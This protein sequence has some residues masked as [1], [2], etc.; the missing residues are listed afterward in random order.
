MDINSKLKQLNRSLHYILLVTVV[1]CGVI[2]RTAS[3][4]NG[5]VP[6]DLQVKLI[7]TALTY[8]K[9]LETRANGQLNIGI[10]YFPESSQ[11]EKEANQFVKTLDGFKDKKI[12]GRSFNGTLLSYADN[13]GLRKK[14]IDKNIDVLYIVHGKKELID[15]VL[16][17]TRSEKILSCTCKAELVTSCGVTMAVGLKDNKPK[18]YLNLSS[19]KSEGADFSA[20]FLRVAEIVGKKESEDRSQK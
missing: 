19:A 20:K 8:D 5:N 9:S 14:I 18:I 3:A 16:K 10:L 17:V 6:V 1:A 2:P 11:S 12:S 7:L 15:K 4:D 13:G